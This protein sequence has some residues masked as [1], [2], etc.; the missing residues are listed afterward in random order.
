MSGS[1]GDRQHLGEAYEEL[2]RRFPDEPYR[3]RFGIIAER[4]RRTRLRVVDGRDDDATGYRSPDD[5]LAELD[6]LRDALVAERM[7]RVAY[8]E[9]LDLRWQV[10]TF[11]FHALSLEVR[12]HSDVHAAAIRALRERGRAGEPTTSL[13]TG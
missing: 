8:G 10:E 1:S 2:A 13:P 12:Q 4:L 5:L 6:E 11:G 7:E 9:L 3:R